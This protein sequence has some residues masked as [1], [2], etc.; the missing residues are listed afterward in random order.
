M[1][2]VAWP[3]AASASHSEGGVRKLVTVSSAWSLVWLASAMPID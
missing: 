1:I 3:V 2:S